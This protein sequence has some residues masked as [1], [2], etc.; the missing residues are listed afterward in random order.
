MNNFA[1]LRI[2]RIPYTKRN[3]DRKAEHKMEEMTAYEK[4]IDF[5]GY[6]SDIK[7][8]ALYLP[9]YHAIPEN[10][11]WWGEG[12]T[13]WTNVKKAQPRFV[14]HDQPRI[15]EAEWGYYDLTD[16]QVLKKQA[17]LARSHGIYA[18][19][20]YY[21][22]FSGKRLLEK[23]IDLLLEH[24]EIDFP[25]FLIWANENWTR[26]WDGENSNIL[27]KQ[28]YSADDPVKFI[29]DLK[30]YIDDPRYMKV[31]GKPVI[32]IYNPLEVPDIS[33]VLC[34]WRKTAEELG[35]GEIQIWSCITDHTAEDAGIDSLVDAEYEFPPRGKGH[36]PSR[37]AEGSGTLWDYGSLVEDAKNYTV[38]S[39]HP[40]Y[41]GTML[42]WD[43]A[44][45]KQV[46]YHCWEGYTPE[47]F[48]RWNRTV[49]SYTRKHFAQEQRFV[50][51][52]AWNEWGEGTYLEPDQK[53]GYAAINALSKAIFDLPYDEASSL[54]LDHGLRKEKHWD[55]DLDH[56]TNIAVHIHVFYLDLIPEFLSA[57]GNIQHPFDLYVSTD[58][59]YKA[60]YIKQAFAEKR[61]LHH[62]LRNLHVAVFDNRGR[63]VIPF[64][65]QMRPV[66]AQYK[67]ICHLHTKKSKHNSIGDQWRRYLLKNL[68][69]SEAIVDDVLYLM[70]SDPAVG[71]VY[72]ETFAAIKPFMVW[73]SDKKNAER[74]AEKMGVE[75][76]MELVHGKDQVIF[77]AGDMFWAKTDAVRQILGHAFAE[78]DIPE[79]K[80]QTDGTIM[81]A[82]ERLWSYTA[83]FNGYRTVQTE[84]LMLIR[85]SDTS[86]VYEEYQRLVNSRMWRLVNKYYQLRDRLLPPGSRRRS[87]AKKLVSFLKK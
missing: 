62:C 18:F 45:R 4:N 74:L 73:G 87:I 82:V 43:N 17:E 28:N 10:D 72:P 7:P 16:V 38:H 44:A 85:T 19:G 80:G 69:G 23:P 65:K 21:Y 58:S 27:I 61:A 54:L 53:Y 26:R 11:A 25:F 52:N 31:D 59:N 63:D 75:I 67:Y 36:I 84:T 34:T 12:F 15:P 42:S 71:I 66:F 29:A 70:E 20:V 47:L 56:G 51:V 49:I 32:G 13:E 57:L 60:E 30:K 3:A 78:E 39:H 40:V 76:K 22:W 41:R 64:L 79:E 83:A 33:G 14:G 68:M 2:R 5:S 86:E 48:Y 6:Q 77:P 8:I 50:F 9:Q 35:I 37:P 46:D 1:V 81:H 24:P 55:S